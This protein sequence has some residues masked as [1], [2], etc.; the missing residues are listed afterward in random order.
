M[1]VKPASLGMFRDNLIRKGLIYAPDH[2]LVNFT[3]PH[4]DDYMRRTSQAGGNGALR[5]G[6][7]V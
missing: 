2:G 7:P 5:P 1:G 3:V 4:F 6:W